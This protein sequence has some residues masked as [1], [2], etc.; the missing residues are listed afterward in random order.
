MRKARKIFRDSPKKRPE[1]QKA[2]RDEIR[3]L[4]A[5]ALK[6]ENAP[7]GYYD[8]SAFRILRYGVLPPLYRKLR[9]DQYCWKLLC[10]CQ[11]SISL[12][13][14]ACAK[15][16]NQV[17]GAANRPAYVLSYQREHYTNLYGARAI[18]DR[19]NRRI[20]EESLALGLSYDP[21]KIRPEDILPIDS[22][23]DFR[24]Q[25]LKKA[26]LKKSMRPKRY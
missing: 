24:Q 6:L 18:K 5:I 16:A 2:F 11:E 9:F 3:L 14:L 8:R 25:Q 7:E 1:F 12:G 20:K 13:L 10:F 4:K 26:I 21:V 22:G 23:G 15:T 19:V 17:S